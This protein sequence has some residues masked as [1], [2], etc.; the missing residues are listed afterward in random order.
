M[1]CFS[2]PTICRPISARRAISIWKPSLAARDAVK[3]AAR[4]NGKAVGGHQVATDPDALAQM[5]EEGFSF[6]AY[7]T[8]MIALRAALKP[9]AR[10]G[11]SR[12]GASVSFRHAWAPADIRESRWHRCWVC[13]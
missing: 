7:G 4:Q 11:K 9:G 8:D 13:R 3:T 12:C 5:I 6:I 1:P 2:A 10:L